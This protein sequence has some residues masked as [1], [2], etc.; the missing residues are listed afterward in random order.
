MCFQPR[1]RNY[2][3]NKTENLELKKYSILNF[4][5]LLDGFNRR[6]KMT[7]KLVIFKSV[8]LKIDQ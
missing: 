2:E 5:K 4:K 6:M 7:E 3:R 1:N 8:N